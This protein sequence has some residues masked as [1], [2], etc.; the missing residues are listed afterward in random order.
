MAKTK[1]IVLIVIIFL[2][3]SILIGCKVTNANSGPLVKKHKVFE[4]DTIPSIPP[5][6]KPMHPIAELPPLKW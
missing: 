4:P 5:Q 6:D 1:K 2:L 3:A